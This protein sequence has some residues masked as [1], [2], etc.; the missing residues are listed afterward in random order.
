MD[1]PAPIHNKWRHLDGHPLGA[2]ER[3]QVVL[4]LARRHLASIHRFIRRASSGTL[5]KMTS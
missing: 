4:E 3:E 5:L 1:I 2:A